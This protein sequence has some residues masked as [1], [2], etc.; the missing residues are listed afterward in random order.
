[1][2]VVC[3]RVYTCLYI[4]TTRG[5]HVSHLSSAAL[6]KMQN[7][8]DEGQCVV[9]NGYVKKTA[10]LEWFTLSVSLL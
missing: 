3:V 4:V 9:K 7:M 10:S 1:M 6:N 2:H 8:I 5:S